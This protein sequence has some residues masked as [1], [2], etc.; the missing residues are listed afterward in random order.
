MIMG[1]VLLYG[2]SKP[3]RTAR[4]D[5]IVVIV[6]LNREDAL[7]CGKRWGCKRA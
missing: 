2:L 6:R 4:G 5:V 3:R 1:S 7:G